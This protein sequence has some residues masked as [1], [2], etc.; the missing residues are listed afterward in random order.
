MTT[1]V[2]IADPP[3]PAPAARWRDPLP[4]FGLTLGWTLAWLGL[5]VLLPLAA[6]LATGDAARAQ[7]HALLAADPHAGRSPSREAVLAYW[8][9]REQVE[10]ADAWLLAA[11]AET[12][13]RPAWAELSAALAS[14]DA[15]RLQRLLDTQADWLPLHD[16]IEAADRAGRTAP[17]QTFAFDALAALPDSDELHQ[18][19]VDRVAG[20]RIA[21]APQFAGFTLRSLRQRPLEERTAAAEASVLLGPRLR[22]SAAQTLTTRASTDAAQWVDPPQRD[23]STRLELG[24][25]F[26]G[27]RTA[28]LT[29]HQRDS[30]MRAEGWRVDGHWRAHPR[31]WAS[32]AVGQGQPAADNAILRAGGER[33]LVRFD[34]YARPSLREFAALSYEAARLHA[35]DGG[36]VGSASALRVEVGHYVRVDYPDLSLRLGL[37][38]LDYRPAPGVAQA[39]LPLLPAAARAGATNARLLPAATT[40]IGLVLAVGEGARERYTRA[41][42]PFAAFGVFDQRAGG[43]GSLWTVGASGSL[44][45][46]DRLSISAAGGSGVGAQPEPFL[47]FT[48]RYQW[49]F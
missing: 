4:G 2:A 31:L 35:Q 29:L 30:L 46:T 44:F 11:Y 17:A 39:L 10:V 36:A 20:S 19:L 26:G 1:A 37:T 9:G 5:I 38:D 3:V 43:S 32:A 14:N 27:E 40:Q 28:R 41:W 7:L 12:L 25:D 15:S 13:A 45:G 22:L 16:R 48:L 42:R 49:M 6:L 34:L 18:R 23:R 47:D 33:D 21:T 8:I 24:H